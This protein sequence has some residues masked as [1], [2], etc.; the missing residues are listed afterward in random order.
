M[1]HKD[2][3][4]DNPHVHVKTI[5]ETGVENYNGTRTQGALYNKLL[6]D[7]K[8]EGKYDWVAFI[9]VDEF[10]DFEEGYNLERLCNEFKDTTGVWLAW[11]MPNV[12]QSALALNAMIIS[13]LARRAT[14]VIS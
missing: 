8:R 5:K 9:D 2:I 4:E 11:K 3:F 10:V 7:F 1:S 14:S 13:T 6:A 12:R